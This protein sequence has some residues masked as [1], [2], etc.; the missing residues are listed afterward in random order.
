M[1]TLLGS[2]HLIT[3]RNHMV[4]VSML[5]T[6]YPLGFSCGEILLTLGIMSSHVSRRTRIAP[7]FVFS[8]AGIRHTDVHREISSLAP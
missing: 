7:G 6:L 5:M 8:C 1:T 4:I 2:C 3:N